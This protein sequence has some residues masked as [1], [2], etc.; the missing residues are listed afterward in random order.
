V[1]PEA[2]AAENGAEQQ[3]EAEPAAAESP[4]VES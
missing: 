2:L 1:Q 3:A 4:R